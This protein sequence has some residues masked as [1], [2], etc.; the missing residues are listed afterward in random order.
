MKPILILLGIGPA[1][2]SCSAR[3]ELPIVKT[4]LIEYFKNKKTCK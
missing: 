3:K 2:L 1:V 4:L